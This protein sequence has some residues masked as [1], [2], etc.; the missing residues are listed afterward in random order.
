MRRNYWWGCRMRE[1]C[2]IDCSSSKAI[3]FK[4]SSRED[5]FVSLNCCLAC[6]SHHSINGILR[7]RVFRRCIEI[8]DLDARFV[9]SDLR[10][11]RKGYMLSC[12]HIARSEID[13]ICWC[14][15]DDIIGCKSEEI[16]RAIVVGF[17]E[18]LRELRDL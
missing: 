14:H 12:I 4:V 2:L 10:C 15:W 6:N 18:W 3:F 1:W 11:L 5:L 16:S 13:V 7:N 8:I 17:V 9:A